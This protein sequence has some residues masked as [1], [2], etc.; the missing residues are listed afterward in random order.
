MPTPQPQPAR[1]AN[2][3]RQSAIDRLFHALGDPTRRAIV[4]ALVEKPATVSKLATPLGVTLTAVMQHLEILES[5]GLVHT[6]KL[7]RVRVCRL[8]PGG[9]GAL[10][11]WIREH[12]TGWEQKLDQLG[13]LLHEEDSIS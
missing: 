3:T 5:A 1:Q 13:E 11:Q 10:E 2:P 8:E 7:G 12:R 9:F 6:E 4:D